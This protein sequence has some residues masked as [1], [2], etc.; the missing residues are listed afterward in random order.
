MSRNSARPSLALAVA[1]LVLAAGLYSNM[2]KAQGPGGQS[3]Q[4]GRSGLGGQ[5]RRGG[6][7]GGFGGGNMVMGTVTGGDANSGV[8]V[9][10]SQAGG[11]QTIHVTAN[12]QFVTQKTIEV[13][14]L[15]VGD[16]VQVQGVP[17]AITASSI[18]AGQL[19]DSF[20]MGGP[21]SG[22]RGNAGGNPGSNQGILLSRGDQG[23]GGRNNP[24]QTMQF[25]TSVTGKVTSTS[26]LTISLND[27]VSIVLKLAPNAKIMKIQNSTINS[28]KNGDTILASGQT[29]NDGSFTANGVAVNVTMGG[30]GGMFG[31]GGPGG[32]GGGFPFGGGNGFGP[33][34]RGGRGPGGPGP[35]P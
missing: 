23:P 3:G 6:G 13:S 26:P 22:R 29:G 15:Q 2:T 4:S 33:G 25:T 8:I 21:G 12:T 35:N 14:A 10:S 17:T 7:F 9:V 18:T 32:F 27:S 19:P 16:Q 20:Q 5:G 28:L 30:P 11:E 31:F 24:Q 34:R 1:G